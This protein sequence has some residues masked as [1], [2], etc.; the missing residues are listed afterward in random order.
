[1]A[2]EEERKTK[3]ADG[4]PRENIEAGERMLKKQVVVTL[5]VQDAINKIGDSP[6]RGIYGN[7]YKDGDA[8]VVGISCRTRRWERNA[9]VS[10]D[11]LS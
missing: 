5:E 3:A 2:E 4:G 7:G 6:L 11:E 1:M 10:G 8:R 9:I